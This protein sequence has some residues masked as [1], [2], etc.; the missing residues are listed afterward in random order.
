VILAYLQFNYTGLL[1][2]LFNSC[3]ICVKHMTILPIQKTQKC[4]NDPFITMNLNLWIPSLFD[5]KGGIQSYS[6]Y[7]FNALQS[8]YPEASYE[9]FLKNDVLRKLPL[10]NANVRFHGSGQT[11]LPFRTIDFASQIISKNSFYPSD[12]IITTH[13]NFA[14][15][16]YLLKKF[17][18]ISYWV[19]AH[20]IEAWDIQKKSVQLGLQN[21]D[22][23]LAVSHY[24]RDRLLEKGN[25][26]PQKV[27][28][29]PNT[30]DSDRFKPSSKPNYLLQQYNLTS[31]QPVILTVA[32]L[33]QQER[34]KG[35]DQILKA[36]P[37]IRKI[38][39][40]I[41]YVLVGKG[42]DRLRVEGIIDKFD[43]Q[44]C[45]TL[46]GFVSDEQ[47]CDY[48]NLCDVFAMPSKKEGFGIVYLEA[49]SCGKPVLGGNQ[50]GA[51][52]ALC[53]GELGALVNP[54]DIEA[55]AKA[56]IQILKKSY[57]NDLMYRPAKLRQ[58]VIDTYGLEVFREKIADLINS[59]YQG[60]KM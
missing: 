27:V 24:T 21:A 28:V 8:L 29:L 58:K 51:I 13:L 3:Y 2:A 53:H 54:D 52:D 9:I 25:L 18:G 20:G 6:R 49:L 10:P 36:L 46:A 48:Y 4:R 22:R 19:V 23:I 16:G 7:L 1:R 50:D 42:E 38:I 30:F 14:F 55:I 15:A 37:Q 11:L 60:E 32:R 34:Y 59:H 5:S 40:D 39:P 45:V 17:R 41:H 57:P 56:L 35:Y 43:L 26:D 33:S 44:D 31:E 47:L 12:L